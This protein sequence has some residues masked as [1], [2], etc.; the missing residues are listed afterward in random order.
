[1]TDF[2]KTSVY[3]DDTPAE[4]V[5]VDLE[6][7]GLFPSDD[8]TLEVGIIVTDKY[9]REKASFQSLILHDGAMQRIDEI[10]QG[11]TEGDKFVFKMHTFNDLFAELVTLEDELFDAHPDIAQMYSYN[12][13]EAA[14]VEFLNQ[15]AGEAKVMPMCGNTI[16]FDRLFLGEHMDKLHDWFHYRNV[17][18]TSVRNLCRMLNPAVYASV[19]RAPEDAKWHR[20]L[21]DLRGSIAEYNFY[22][23]NFLFES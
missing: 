16:N 1:M 9:G 12:G 18:I 22:R 17:D 20:P 23:Q 7:T 13:V 21:E 15:Y 6:T 10:K 5:W 4:M 8:Y 3:N 19:P 11:R 2:R 14:A